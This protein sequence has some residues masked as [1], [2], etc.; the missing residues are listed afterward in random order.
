MS[1]VFE[2]DV[3]AI[4]LSIYVYEALW[5]CNG[6]YRWLS[7]QIRKSKSKSIHQLLK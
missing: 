6:T 4:S 7:Y 5:N 1:I 2:I 3:V